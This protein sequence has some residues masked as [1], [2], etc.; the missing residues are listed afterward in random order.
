M[1]IK[2]KKDEQKKKKKKTLKIINKSMFF[3][4]LDLILQ[5][6]YF[7]ERTQI[8][9]KMCPFKLYYERNHHYIV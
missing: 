8:F 1:N 6:S 9:F 5:M 3:F 7:K 2:K 4:L